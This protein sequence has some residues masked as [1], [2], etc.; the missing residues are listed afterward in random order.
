[1][2][3]P[4]PEKSRNHPKRKNSPDFVPTERDQEILKLIYEHR[5]LDSKLIWHLLESPK[6]HETEYKIGAD[7][8]KRPSK[9]GFGSKAL[10]SRLT[11]LDQEKYVYRRRRADLPEGGVHGLSRLVYSLGPKSCSILPKIVDA[12]SSDIRKIVES[13]RRARTH[14]YEHS[15]KIAEFKAILKLACN[16]SNGNVNLLFWEQGQILRD[17]VYG[18]NLM[19][20]EQ[21][22]SVYPDAFFAINVR[23]K[24]TTCFFAEFDRGSM[25]IIRTDD[26]SDISKKVLGYWFYRKTK[27]HANRYF[28]TKYPNGEVSGLFVKDERSANV[29]NIDLEP[30]R[31]F[32]VLFVVPGQLSKDG[33]TKGRIA[34]ILS[35][36]PKFGRDVSSSALFWFST[37]DMF[38]IEEPN[39]IFSKSWITPNPQKGLQSLIE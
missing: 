30:I 34:N 28:Y 4:S 17:F 35:S 2:K 9:Y 11:K 16:N 8:K 3:K 5:F 23:G 32:T 21:R 20:R 7:G 26:N 39:S 14:F 6:S 10:L 37:L 27:R 36:F 19:G 1:M 22:L 24:G 13:N 25:P 38:S 33:N 31:G 12:S 15:I 18:M 29:S